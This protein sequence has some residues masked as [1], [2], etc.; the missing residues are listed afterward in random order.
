MGN[1]KS[2]IRK[3]EAFL[4]VEEALAGAL[5]KLEE[6]NSRVQQLL[7]QEAPAGGE[8]EG[9]APEKTAPSP[10]TPNEKQASENTHES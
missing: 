4:D 3:D 7:E 2:I 10:D 8:M 6:A 1:K 9:K 5:A